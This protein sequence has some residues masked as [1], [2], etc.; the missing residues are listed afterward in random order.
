M[1]DQ[2]KTKAQLVNELRELR[3]RITEL[4][5]AQV[6]RDRVEQAL[7]ES[8]ERYRN[9]VELAPDGILTGNLKGVATSCN[10][11]FLKLTGFSREEIVGTHISRFPTLRIQDIP[12][13][14]K[15]ILSAM[16]GKSINPFE[17]IWVHKDGTHRWGEAHVGLMKADSRIAGLQLILR[18]ITERKQ[19]EEERE[20]LMAQIQGQAQ[21]MQ[22]ILDTVPEG[23]LLLDADAQIVLANPVAEREL[24]VL[25]DAKIGDTLMGLG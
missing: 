21:R 1:K 22:Q 10:S 25:A 7:R 9:I 18:D 16:R 14:V 19:A 12:K 6:E 5:A 11:A 24:V 3:Q 23:V 15:V 17:F 20:R 13:Y 8:E 4:E 2:D